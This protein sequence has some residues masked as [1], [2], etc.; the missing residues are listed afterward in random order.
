MPYGLGS[1]KRK[2]MPE[3]EAFRILNAAWEKGITTLDTSPEYG[4]AEERVFRFMKENSTRK[5]HIISKIKNI[6]SEKHSA[7][8]FIKDWFTKSP[9]V[10]LDN[11]LSL[12]VL[13]HNEADIR[14]KICYPS[15]R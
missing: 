6:P 5:F 4:L 3:A 15:I 9:F 11:C 1:W 7:Q 2:L 13:L 8:S 14:R 12:S 10:D